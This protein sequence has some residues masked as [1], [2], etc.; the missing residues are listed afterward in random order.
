VT[1]GVQE[2]IRSVVALHVTCQVM[3]SKRLR[4]PEEE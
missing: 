1:K 4:V 3:E 2:L